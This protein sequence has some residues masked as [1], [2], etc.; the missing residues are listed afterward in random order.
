MAAGEEPVAPEDLDV[1]WLVEEMRLVRDD[2]R[3]KPIAVFEGDQRPRPSFIPR[4]FLIL[5]EES[6]VAER[7]CEGKPVRFLHACVEV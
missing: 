7:G 4:P 6:G 5:L 3:H 2:D 1:R